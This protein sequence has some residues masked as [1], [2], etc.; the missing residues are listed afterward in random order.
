M[1]INF[2]FYIILVYCYSFEMSEK[3]TFVTLHMT[4]S[5]VNSTK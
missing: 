4:N 5:H 3:G 2:P 1:P